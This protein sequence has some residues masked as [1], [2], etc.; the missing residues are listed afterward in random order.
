MHPPLRSRLRVR[1]RPPAAPLGYLA[2]TFGLDVGPV[3]HEAALLEMLRELG[4]T[5][6]P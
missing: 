6:K 3:L 4:L 1:P 5:K 2:G